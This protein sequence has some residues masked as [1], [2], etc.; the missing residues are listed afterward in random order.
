MVRVDADVSLQAGAGG[1]GAKMVIPGGTLGSVTAPATVYVLGK[2]DVKNTVN[3]IYGTL[4][5]HGNGVPGSSGS[6]TD[7][8]FQG[9]HTVTTVLPGAGV[10]HS[11]PFAI[12][13]YNPNEGPPPAQTIYLDISNSGVLITG[14]VYTGGTVDFGPNIITGT[15][16]GYTV[17]ANN[18]ATSFTYTSAYENAIPPPGFSTPALTLPS[19]IASGTWLKCRR[20]DSLAAVCD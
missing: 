3:T 1:A 10:P 17:N 18:A 5:F 7:L 9:P 15:V 8:H 14:M 6:A 4:I 11:Y 19:V 16:M 12:L 2:L 20:A 13:G